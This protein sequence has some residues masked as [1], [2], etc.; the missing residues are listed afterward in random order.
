[1][2][3]NTLQQLKDIQDLLKQG[4]ITS[5]EAARLK[6]QVMAQA[7][8]STNV[9]PAPQGAAVQ[10]SANNGKKTAIIMGIIAAVLAVVAAIVLMPSHQ[11]PVPQVQIATA[12]TPTQPGTNANPPA[13]A[14]ATEAA[15]AEPSDYRS[16]D[17]MNKG[18]YMSGTQDVS[19]DFHISVWNGEGTLS[20]SAGHSSRQRRKVTVDSYDPGSGSLVL[21]SYMEDGRYVGRYVGTVSSSGSY[22]GKFTNYKGVSLKFDVKVKET[23]DPAPPSDWKS[24][25]RN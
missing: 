13:A 23:F 9:A 8:E 20:F 11:E 5:D 18:A 16:V 12:T 21:S 6:A 15:P 17:F 1:M 22:A 2:S 4:A 24:K 10:D 19:H 25:G 3:N 7:T 14:P